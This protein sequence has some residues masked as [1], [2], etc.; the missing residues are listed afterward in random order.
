MQRLV[1]FLRIATATSLTTLCAAGTA[2]AAEIPL[3][4]D[5][6]DVR[7]AATLLLPEGDGPHP[8]AVFLHGSG[9]HTRDDQRPYAQL[10][11]DAGVGALISD[12]RGSGASTGD[13][14]HASLHDLAR[15]GAAGYLAVSDRPEVDTGRIGV[16]GGSQAGWVAPVMHAM[17]R[18]IAF[19]ILL[20]GGGIRPRESEMW[21]YRRALE[22]RGATPAE[23]ARAETLLARYFDY[24]AT[25]SRRE[26]LMTAIESVRDEAWYA[27][28]RLDRV[29]PSPDSRPAWEW[30]AT[31]DPMP[32]METMTAPTLLLFGD[33]DGVQPHDLAAA[34]WREGLARAGNDRVVIEVLPGAD[35]MLRLGGGDEHG[36]GG[37]GGERPFH[38]DLARTIREWV[39][40]HVLAPRE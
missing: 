21:A 38:G 8:V 34:R 36:G 7:I 33:D 12:K 16:F 17:Q 4:F 5:S 20:S 40:P 19:F 35:H 25:G 30:V 26:E 10:L 27:A 2:R 11:L 39:E 9:P 37:H 29:M 23:R 15:D 18:R 22:H 31:F 3:S 32:L 1:I 13:W 6:G 14:S 24:L 28:L